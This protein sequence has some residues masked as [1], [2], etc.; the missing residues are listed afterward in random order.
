MAPEQ[1]LSRTD[2]T[3]SVP[4]VRLDAIYTRHIGAALGMII[5]NR[6]IRLRIVRYNRRGMATSAS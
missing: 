3:V 4:F 2:S 1:T 5:P 6:R